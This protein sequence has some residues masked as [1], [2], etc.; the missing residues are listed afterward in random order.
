MESLKQTTLKSPAQTQDWLG[1]SG[2]SVSSSEGK[3]VNSTFEKSEQ[4]KMGHDKKESEVETNFTNSHVHLQLDRVQRA[5][6]TGDE[7]HSSG[8]SNG[9]ASTSSG[10]SGQQQRPLSAVTELHLGLSSS[11]TSSSKGLSLGSS[12]PTL[13]VS[14]LPKCRETDQPPERSE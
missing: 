1:H 11:T 9:V 14:R 12:Q 8:S 13:R 7:P 3:H 10:C 6:G 2:T 5:D 4:E